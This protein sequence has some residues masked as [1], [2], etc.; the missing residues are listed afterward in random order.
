MMTT[1]D[2]QLTVYDW[3]SVDCTKVA[4][5]ETDITVCRFAKMKYFNC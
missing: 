4:T 1:H 5:S 3:C 2:W